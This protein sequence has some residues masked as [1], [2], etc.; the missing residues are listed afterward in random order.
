[1]SAFTKEELEAF[2]VIADDLLEKGII[3]IRKTKKGGSIRVKTGRKSRV[4]YNF[5]FFTPTKE[6]RRLIR[7]TVLDSMLIEDKKYFPKSAKEIARKYI[8]HIFFLPN[9]DSSFNE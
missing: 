7:Q 1:M 3:E 4:Y 5:T 9:D 6:I 2:D 8:S